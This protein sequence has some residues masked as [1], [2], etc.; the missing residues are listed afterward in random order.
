M[1]D[2]LAMK[3]DSVDGEILWLQTLGGDD[4]LNDRA[5]DVAVDADGDAVLSGIS[6]NADDSASWLTIKL[7]GEYGGEIW[8]R[9]EDGALNNETRACW[10][11]LDEAGNAIMATR[12][13]VSG[14][15][16]NAVL[17]K[18]AAADGATIWAS[19]YNGPASGS[20]DPRSM[21]LDSGANPILVGVSG[22]DYMT[23]RFDGASGD[24]VWSAT[25]DG[26]PGWYDLANA[27]AVGPAG[28]I[29]VTGFSDGSGSSWDVAT[30][31]YDADSGDEQWV[32]RFDGVSSQTDEARALAVG[33]G[34]LFVA[35]YTYGLVTD[36]DLLLLGYGFA[37]TGLA[38]L[39]QAAGGLSAWPNPFRLR[40]TLLL[41]LPRD[42]RARVEIFDISGRLLRSFN[43]GLVSAGTHPL[44]WDGRDSR[45]RPVPAGVYL[46]RARAAGGSHEVKIINLD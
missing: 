12:N 3:L 24:L 38:D 8:S 40:S 14:E 36:M 31:A 21:I 10:L 19:E 44:I 18:F 13:W 28:E 25:Y 5:W 17:T 22:G 39:P 37:A 46:A 35:G 32:L 6:Q 4:H 29:I 1:D 43:P 34:M 41:D 30:V 2:I 11:G 27:A 26:P 7:D 23:L 16:F 9:R 20:D 15:S 33:E 42:A 45:G